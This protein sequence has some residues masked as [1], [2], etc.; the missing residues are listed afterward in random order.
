VVRIVPDELWE[1]LLKVPLAPIWRLEG[2]SVELADD[3]SSL[4]DLI[5]RDSFSILFHE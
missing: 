1:T 4:G 3:G 5:H 2:L